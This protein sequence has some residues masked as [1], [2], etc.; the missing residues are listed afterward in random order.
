[1]SVQSILDES[2]S[3]RDLELKAD[4]A[5]SVT[6]APGVRYSDT[7]I[8]VAMDSY[9][10]PVEGRAARLMSWIMSAAPMNFPLLELG[11]R[12]L[13]TAKTLRDRWTAGFNYSVKG[14]M[15]RLSAIIRSNEERIKGIEGSIAAQITKVAEKIVEEAGEAAP[16]IPSLVPWWVWAGGAGVAALALSSKF[17]SNPA[18][19]LLPL[20]LVGG[21]A[22][23][24]AKVIKEKQK[25]SP[26][27]LRE[28]AEQLRGQANALERLGDNASA[29]GLRRQAEQ[30]DQ[31]AAVIE[32][33]EFVGPP[34]PE[35]LMQAG[36]PEFSVN[37]QVEAYLKAA[38]DRRATAEILRKQR[39]PE[40]AILPLEHEAVMFE[41]M[42]SAVEKR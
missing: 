20:L 7:Q 23:V 40:S 27:A 34:A 11:E 32:A 6:F 13:A 4:G 8:R 29:Y 37:P 3:L 30:L 15:D 1:M 28:G 24:A 38:A 41:Q 16:K 42:A 22:I 26:K 25:K 21:G 17:S 2:A 18:G 14:E 12:H 39:M 5:I 31:E 36:R 19:G 33:R 9:V 35:A 10:K